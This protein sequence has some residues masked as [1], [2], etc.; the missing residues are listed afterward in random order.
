VYLVVA[1]PPFAPEYWLLAD[2]L[3]HD[4]SLA[5]EGV[6]TTEY[7]PL[8]AIFLAGIRLVARDRLF[9]VRLLQVAMA[10]TGAIYLYRL[11]EAL[12]GRARV[13]V[14]SAGLYAF[15]PLLVREAVVHGEATLMIP[16]L[17]AFT[18]YFVMSRTTFGAAVAG[19][20]LGIVIL[21]RSMAVPLVAAGAVLLVA[22]RRYREA[23]ALS[24]AALLVIAPMLARSTLCVSSRRRLVSFVLK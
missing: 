15:D 24:S 5:I 20:W 11:A 4:G 17:V 23:L 9:L 3:L 8:Y 22:D 2:G 12:T 1:R 13:A 7:E 6:K 18:Y 16:L 19:V 21:T 14:I 10:S